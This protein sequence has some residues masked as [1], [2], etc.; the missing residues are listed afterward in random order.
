MKQD[1]LTFKI[2]QIG[3]MKYTRIYYLLSLFC[4]YSFKI[5]WQKLCFLAQKWQLNFFHIELESAMMQ[6]VVLYFSFM[7]VGLKFPIWPQFLN[8]AINL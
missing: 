4:E 1:W 2:I 8:K 6:C 5:V 7:L 3:S